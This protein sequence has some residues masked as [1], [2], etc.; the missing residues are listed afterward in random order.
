MIKV[1]H[2]N[3]PPYLREL[4][5]FLTDYHARRSLVTRHSRDVAFPRHNK[6]MFEASFSYLCPL[7]YNR[8][9]TNIKNQICH[10]GYFE[11]YEKICQ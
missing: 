10:V 6:A 8:L 3:K 11:R 4:V 5:H 7:Y 2:T 9:P 1:L